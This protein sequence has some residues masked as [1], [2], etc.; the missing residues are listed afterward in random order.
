MTGKEINKFLPLSEATYYI[1]LS[2]TEPLHGYGIMQKVEGMSRGLVRIGPGTMYGAFNTLE[3]EGLIRMVREEQRRKSYALTDKG[4]QVLA[5]Q[6]H[7]IEIMHGNG[8][9]VLSQL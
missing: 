3:K 1:L 2:L 7:R 9:A 8:Q 6:I 4:R 5:A